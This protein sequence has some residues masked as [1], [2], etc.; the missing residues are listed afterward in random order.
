MSVYGEIFDITIIG[1][2][3]VG[4]YGALY[5]GSRGLRV[6]LIES[7]AQAGGRLI[8]H[9]PEK[10]I[11]DVAGHPEIK[12]RVLIDRLLEQV[13]RHHHELFLN[14]RVTR[15]TRGDDG[16]IS[17]HT[18]A[19][20]HRSRAVVI[21]A[22]VGAFLPDKLQLPHHAGMDASGIHYH[23]E[24]KEKFAG[25][26]VVIVGTGDNA[27]EW[28]MSL[29][30]TAKQVTLVHRLNRLGAPEDVQQA[31][32]ESGITLRFPFWELKEVHGEDRL[33]AVTIVDSSTGAQ[34]RIECDALVLNIGS[35]VNLNDF[36]SWGLSVGLNSIAT[37]ERMATNMPG[38]YAAG[39]I[40]THPGKIKLISTGAGEAA[41]AIANASEWVAARARENRRSDAGAAPVLAEGTLFYSGFE[42]VQMAILLERQAMQFFQTAFRRAG[43]ESARELFA[44]MQRQTLDTV[45]TLQQE[46][47]PA[48]GAGKYAQEDLDD[49]AVAYLQSMTGKHLF[50]GLDLAKEALKNS[51]SDLQNIYTGIRISEDL[52]SFLER[53]AKEANLVRARDI[54][55]RLALDKKQAVEQLRVA[56]AQL[57]DVGVVD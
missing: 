35:I 56:Q 3:P 10:I 19:G 43:G 5:A 50:G 38:V 12:A 16:V 27:L 20:E 31:L 9:Y 53:L 33:Q 57:M 44:R 4:L 18:S 40:V 25:K 52:K 41:I 8:T 34:E 21:S 24:K 17:L 32:H 1:A 45:E 51:G 47:L 26:R 22:G 39:D 48:F 49:T 54:F 42:A 11:Y 55:M 6:K 37:D 46:A 36:K 29:R 14:Q 15:L 23:I 2:G 28:A 7:G 30:A 13:K